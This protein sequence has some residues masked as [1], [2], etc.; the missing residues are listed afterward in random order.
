MI[1]TPLVDIL[2][3]LL[4]G[5]AQHAQ[6][7]L[8]AKGKGGELQLGKAG[9][10]LLAL[11]LWHLPQVSSRRSCLSHEL[12]EVKAHLLPLPHGVVG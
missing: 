3:V 9:R 4:R 7:V 8:E 10:N 1:P 2:Q 5:E 12:L 11:Y 6:G